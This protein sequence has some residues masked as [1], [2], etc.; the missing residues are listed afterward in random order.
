MVNKG[1][2]DSSQENNQ[3]ASTYMKKCSPSLVTKEMEIRT[4]VN[5]TADSKHS[6]NWRWPW[7]KSPTWEACGIMEHSHP[8]ES[9]QT[10]S[11]YWR[12]KCRYSVADTFTSK[13][14]CWY[15]WVRDAGDVR[16]VVWFHSHK[17]R[18]P[19]FKSGGLGVALEEE[20][21]VGGLGEAPNTVNI[22]FLKL[23][24][25]YKLVF[26]EFYAWDLYTL[27][28]R[29]TSIKKPKSKSQICLEKAIHFLLHLSPKRHPVFP[30]GAPAGVIFEKHNS[31]LKV[32]LLICL[33]GP[34]WLRVLGVAN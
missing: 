21:V 29:Y 30:N 32:S 6:S 8:A 9:V 34:P 5:T 23:S 13:L 24:G 25:R 33:Q 1:E 12:W 19:E 20:G 26:T 14:L 27:I 10:V 4:T 16:M 3:M 28:Y 2:L 18:R 31:N 17:I 7:W 11:I 22:F 15:Y